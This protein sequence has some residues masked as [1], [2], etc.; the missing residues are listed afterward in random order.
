LIGFAEPSMQP[1][2]SQWQSLD[3]CPQSLAVDAPAQHCAFDACH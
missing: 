1:P 2:L 3:I